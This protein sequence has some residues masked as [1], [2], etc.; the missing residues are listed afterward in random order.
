MP[1]VMMPVPEEHV[2]ASC[3]SSSGP[4]RGPRSSPGTRSRS[5]EVFL[6]VDEAARSLLAFVARSA[7]D[8]S[9]LD[10]ADA[11]RKIQ[12]TVPRDRSAS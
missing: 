7:A 11:A 6:E 8:G 9:D 12:L 1:Y 4:S 2:E 3:I 10:A 5:A